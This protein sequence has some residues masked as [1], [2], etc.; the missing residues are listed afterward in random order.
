MLISSYFLPLFTCI[1]WL[2]PLWKWKDQTLYSHPHAYKSWQWCFQPESVDLILLSQA[3]NRS[4]TLSLQ[5]L[6]VIRG[7]TVHV[8]C[9]VFPLGGPFMSQ[10]V[11]MLVNTTVKLSFPPILSDNRKKNANPRSKAM[12]PWHYWT[13][14]RCDLHHCGCNGLQCFPLNVSQPV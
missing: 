14:W 3:L 7:L 8:K 6:E 5:L 12:F 2:S 11:T 10:T 9:K 13:M 4:D 1:M